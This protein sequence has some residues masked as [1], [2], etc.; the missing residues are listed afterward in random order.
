MAMLAALDRADLWFVADRLERK[1]FLAS[2]E[3]SSA[4]LEFKRYLA[5]V[6]L[7]HRGIEMAS[8]KVDEVWHAFILFTREYQ[9]FCQAI[10]GEFIHH[11]PRTSRGSAAPA[12][13][14]SFGQAYRQVFGEPG[15]LWARPLAQRSADCGEGEC[16]GEGVTPRVTLLADC[17]EGECSA[18]G[19]GDRVPALLQADCGAGDCTSEA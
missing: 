12:R 19:V 3:I 5:L 14:D 1:G 15:G 18:E 4:I 16:T 8:P 11:A 2:D 9:E 7:G 17:G 13:G 10:F 6:G